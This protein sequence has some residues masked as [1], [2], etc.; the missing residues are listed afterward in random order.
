MDPELA[1]SLLTDFTSTIHRAPYPAISP[2][3]PS[4]SQEGKTVLITGGGVGIGKAIAH[5]FLL[6]S[7][8]TIVIIGRRISNLE[9]TKTELEAAGYHAGK[10][11][12]IIAKSCDVTNDQQ[13][14]ELWDGLEKD[15]VHVDVLVLN[16]A[17]DTPSQTLFE[18]GINQVWSMFEANVKGPLH[19]AERFYKQPSQG[20]TERKVNTFK[21]T[22]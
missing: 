8:A 12:K 1:D 3:K 21:P 19:F 11:V 14:K 9:E 20:R 17:M 2:E 4:L 6:A 16:S 10:T 18:L 5:N 7:A 13:V 15:G 22:C